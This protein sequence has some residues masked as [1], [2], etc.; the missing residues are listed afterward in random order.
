[1]SDPDPKVKVVNS[2][3]SAGWVIAVIAICLLLVGGYVFR[4]AIFGASS[5]DINI[6]VDLPEG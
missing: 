4:D 6:K 1:M 2:G 5:N 3:G